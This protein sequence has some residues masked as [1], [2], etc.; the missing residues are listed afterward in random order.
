[1]TWG[2]L[3]NFLQN[4]QNSFA[5]VDTEQIFWYNVEEGHFNI[6]EVDQ[7]Q[8]QT[9]SRGAKMKYYFVQ[10]YQKYPLMRLEDFVKQAYQAQFGCGHLLGGNVEQYIRNE[11]VKASPTGNLW[12]AIGNGMCRVNLGDCRQRGY[13]PSLIANVMKI[14]VPQGTTEGLESMLQT[15]GDL[16]LEHRVDVDH[17]ALVAFLANYR[18]QGYPPIHHSPT[19]RLNYKPHYRVMPTVWA[20]LLPVLFRVDRLLQSKQHVL[21]A[22]DGPSGSGKTT[23]AKLVA[24][25]YDCPI[26]HTDDMGLG[27]SF[28]TMTQLASSTQNP[29]CQAVQKVVQNAKSGNACAYFTQSG[30]QIEVPKSSVTVVEGTFCT[31]NTLQ[32]LYDVKVHLSVSP[33]EQIVRLFGNSANYQQLAEHPFKLQNTFFRQA[34]KDGVVDIDTTTRFQS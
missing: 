13:L 6:L 34:N 4:T 33:R 25:Y 30:E 11:M 31:C 17:N 5:S 8:R 10:S 32:Y 19:F 12:D 9:N 2:A 1:M 29:N 22:L 21:V 26:V 28:F 27:G 16:A 7:R 3:L 23:L 14:S 15:L 20:Q 18:Q 24:K